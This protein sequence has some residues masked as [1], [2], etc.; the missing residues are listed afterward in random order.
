[1]TSHP[2][3]ASVIA[4]GFYVD[5]LMTSAPTIEDVIEI[6]QQVIEV[7]NKGGFPLRTIATNDASII[8]D[9]TAVDRED[10]IQVEDVD[11]VK[12]LGLKWSPFLD[13]FLFSYTQPLVSSKVSKRIILSNIARFFDPLGL[14][15]PLMVTCK[16][17]LQQLWKFR[18]NWG[19]SVPP[20][21]YTQWESFCTKL[22]L[23]ENLRVTRL[24]ACDYNST[25]HAFVDASTRAY[26]ATIYVVSNST[27]AL[28]CAKSYVAPTKEVSLFRLKLSAAVLLAELLEFVYKKIHHNTGNV[29]CWTESLIMLAWTKGDPSRWTTFVSNRVTKI[30][31]LTHHYYWHH[32]PSELNPAEIL[33]RGTKADK[34]ID[35]SLWFHGPHFL[36]QDAQHW[37]PPSSNAINDNNIPEQRRHNIVLLTNPTTDI[38]SE[39]KCVTNY[40]KLL[41]IMCYV[42]RFA[43]A[44]RGIRTN[45]NSITASEINHHFSPFVASS[46]VPNSLMNYPCFK[47][48]ASFIGS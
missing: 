11:Y 27:S 10:I 22:P 23:V 14:L 34:F 32:V 41:R 18:L 47:R 12:E 8:A 13:N 21:N 19:E 26:G 45:Q 20:S 1:M 4:N 46:K 39:H 35:N 2:I 6:K 38:I 25:T 30:Q 40:N 3:G 7:L 33:S 29:Q 15:N 31:L 42:R 16:I 37:P 48:T 9:V 28:L 36:T 17:L 24:V 5:K 44:S 43:D